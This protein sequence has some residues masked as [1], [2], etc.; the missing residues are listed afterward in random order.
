MHT[1]NINA[2]IIRTIEA[3]K[4]DLEN[5]KYV[6]TTPETSGPVVCPMSMIEPRIPMDFLVVADSDLNSG[7]L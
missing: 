7:T 2:A 1:L 6:A 4:K 5:P 3:A